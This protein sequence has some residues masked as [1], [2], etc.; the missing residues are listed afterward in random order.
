MLW[1]DVSGAYIGGGDTYLQVLIG[2][3]SFCV[4]MP[5]I[6][7][8]SSS[9]SGDSLKGGISIFQFLPPS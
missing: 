8:T 3:R 2:G 7:I 5:C 4:M 1:L 9:F 6:L